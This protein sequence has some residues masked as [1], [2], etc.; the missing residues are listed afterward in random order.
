[1]IRATEGCSLG[2]KRTKTKP[3]QISISIGFRPH[4]LRSSS[5][6]VSGRAGERSVPS[7]L[8]DQAWK[9]QTMAALHSPRS[10]GTTREPRW[11]QTLWKARTS[12]SRPRTISARSPAMSKQMYWPASGMSLTWQAICQRR[13]KRLSFSSSN[14]SRL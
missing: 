3:C 2:L 4:S 8:Y 11:R 6:S 1:M 10:S 5:G 14:I 13:R 12:P 7:R 9:G